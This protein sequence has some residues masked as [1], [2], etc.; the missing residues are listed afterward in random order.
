LIEELEFW[1]LGDVEVMSLQEIMKEK[2]P[3]MVGEK[4]YSK[5][6]SLETLNLKK[7]LSQKLI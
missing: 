7:L 5:W 2:P 4:C 3:K 6:E 1:G